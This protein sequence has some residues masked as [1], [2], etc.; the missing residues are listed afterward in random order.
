MLRHTD[1][2]LLACE[3]TRENACER[4]AGI[5]SGGFK[6]RLAGILE[7]GSHPCEAGVRT[8][9]RRECFLEQTESLGR[10]SRGSRENPCFAGEGGESASWNKPSLSVEKAG[11]LTPASQGREAVVF[12]QQARKALLEGFFFNSVQIC[13]IRERIGV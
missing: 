5:L 8:P 2:L 6:K 3:A 12:I 1:S 7:S 10:K 13:K 9:G 4:L 11:I